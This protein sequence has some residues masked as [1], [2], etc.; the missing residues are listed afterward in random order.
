[1]KVYDLRYTGIRLGILLVPKALEEDA[2][3]QQWFKEF[4]ISPVEA[5]ELDAAQV[6]IG[7]KSLQEWEDEYYE[8]PVLDAM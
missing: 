7:P 3:T 6:C 1:M 2:L 5:R 4:D 8:K